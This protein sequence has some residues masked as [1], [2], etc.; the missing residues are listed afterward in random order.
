MKVTCEIIEDLLPL[1]VDN[2]CS[3]QSRQAVEEQAT[4]SF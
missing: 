2:V 1:Y 4:N 3:K